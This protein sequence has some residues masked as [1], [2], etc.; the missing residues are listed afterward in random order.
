MNAAKQKTPMLAARPNG[1]SE[2]LCRQI[3]ESY[4]LP[5]VHAI[6]RCAIEIYNDVSLTESRPLQVLLEERKTIL[7]ELFVYNDE[8]GELLRRFSSRLNATLLNAY[9]R[10][11]KVYRK[12]ARK[13]CGVNVKGYICFANDFT[14]YHPAKAEIYRNTDGE[15][16]WDALNSEEAENGWGRHNSFVQ[17]EICRMLPEQS[18]L[19]FL[20]LNDEDD[21][22]TDTTPQVRGKWENGLGLN[23]HSHALIDHSL[24]SLYDLMFIR[25]YQIYYQTEYKDSG[26]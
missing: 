7:N 6:E 18:E 9:R 5:A 8:T 25:D 1:P 20:G 3:Q 10:C 24:M 23:I 16:I 2:D 11:C 13:H 14:Y 17:I 15:T 12:M 26:G 19:G 21:D 4:A 22:W